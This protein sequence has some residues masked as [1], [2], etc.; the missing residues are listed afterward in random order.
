M[1]EKIISHHNQHLHNKVFLSIYIS[2]FHQDIS[3]AMMAFRLIFPC[4]VTVNYGF[5]QNDSNS[6]SD[7]SIYF[8]LTCFCEIESIIPTC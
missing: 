2:N 3:Y 4:E 7:L 1:C 6:H 8:N 5:I